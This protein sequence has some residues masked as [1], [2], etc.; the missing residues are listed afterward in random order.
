M[1]ERV[2]QREIHE[3]LITEMS[4]RDVVERFLREIA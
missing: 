1:L 4:L 3:R 2:A